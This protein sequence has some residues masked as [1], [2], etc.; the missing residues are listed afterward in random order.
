MDSAESFGTRRRL[1]LVGAVNFRDLGGYRSAD[2]RRVMWRTL[3]RADS[4]AELITADVERI[5]A[6]GLRTLFDLRHEDE[7]TLKPNRLPAGSPLRVRAL[8]FYPYEAA[9][10][11]EGINDGS[12]KADDIEHRMRALYR[13]FPL[14]H[15]TEYGQLLE[16]L[17]ERDALPALI[18]CTSGKDR[19]GFAVAIVFMA[20]GVPRE[21]IMKDYLLTNR[22]RR[23]LSFMLR[24]GLAPD[25]VSALKGAHPDYLQAAF[26][27]IDEEWGAEAAFLAEA[28]GFDADCCGELRARL[29]EPSGGV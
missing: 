21:T 17:L 16:G 8:G 19:T 29:L 26:S 15:V 1:P 22:Y 5:A 3:Y 11:V 4:L 18:H 9:E 23:D 27:T 24:P 12:L 20:L 7:R 28:L 25:V 14:D 6:L 10:M 2:G 13:R